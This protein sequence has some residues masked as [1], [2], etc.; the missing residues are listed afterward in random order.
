MG[1]APA[2]ARFELEIRLKS[3]SGDEIFIKDTKF[4]NTIFQP[5]MKYTV[6]SYIN[7]PEDMPRGKYDVALRLF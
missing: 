3:E 6:R 7:L 5:G 2:Y 1:F 4:D